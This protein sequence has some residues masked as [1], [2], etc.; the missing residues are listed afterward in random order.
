[1][2]G[3]ALLGV[4][5]LSV[6]TACT[7]PPTLTALVQNSGPEHTLVEVQGADL[8][9]ASIVWDA[10]LPSE[11]T[12]PGGFLT[13]AMF[14][15]PPGAAAG[16][17]PVAIQNNAGRSSTMNFTVTAPQAFGPPRV[18]HV[19]IVGTPTFA[20]GNVNTLLYL[21]GA[22]ID[23]GAV[24]F[25][26]GAEVG[27]ATH[28]ALRADRHGVDP[29]RL[30]FPIF[31]YLSLL[32]AA[33]AKPAGATIA[34]TVRNLDG[35][36]SAPF[37]FQLPA[38]LATLDSDGDSLRD[39]WETNGFDANGDGTIDID[40]KALGCLP[41]RRDILLEVDVMTGLANPPMPGA[42][43][44]T[45]AMFAA[46]PVIQPTQN[47]INLILDTS[48]TVPFWDIIDFDVTDSVPLSTANF[49]TLKAANFNNAIRDNIYHYA[50]WAN[51]RPGGS[52]G[53]SDIQFDN[54][55]NVSGPGDDLIVSLD[56][57]GASFNTIRSQAG[58]LAHE[59]GHNLGQ[60]HGG[61]NNVTKKPNYWSVMSYTWQLRTGKTN[62]Q[63][64]ADVTCPP[65]YYAAAGATEVNGALPAMFNDVIDYSEGMGPVLTENNN[66]LS[67]LLGVCGQAVD[68][69]N[70]GDQNDQNFNADADDNGAIGGAVTDF[71]NW[72]ALRFNGP[73]SDGQFTP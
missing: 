69:N 3:R 31:H 15:V 8:F 35:V 2:R 16:A 57:F 48:G 62:A 37:N 63:R 32:A 24:V 23:V 66:T 46:A 34:V 58:T 7:K 18:D 9:L 47:G 54:N 12:I 71:A 33:P 43:D 36:M 44:A 41:N 52:S 30:G 50:I 55:N 22:N 10:G 64:R 26:D 65:F 4:L 14:S 11:K 67:E 39:T 56:D 25:V 27:T 72:R 70:D 38:S 60:Q 61:N 59:F 19:M 6:L 20:G 68:W 42:F 29:A 21:D 40:L 5:A 17:H 45:R 28:K 49:G 1:M 53:R 13:A 73:A 51:A